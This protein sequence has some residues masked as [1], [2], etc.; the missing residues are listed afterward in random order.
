MLGRSIGLVYA[1]PMITFWSKG[2]FQPR[3]K[4]ITAGV[5][6]LYLCQG[7]IGWWMVK[8]GLKDKNET[9]EVDKTP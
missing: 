4:K 9:S 3:L 2:Y 1:L 5:L 8:S 6:G 7:L